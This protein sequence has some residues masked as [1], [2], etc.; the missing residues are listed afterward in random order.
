LIWSIQLQL[1][2]VAFQRGG[3][4]GVLGAD[5]G[6]VQRVLGLLVVDLGDDADVG[7]AVVALQRALGRQAVDLGG[8]GFLLGQQLL[9][10]RQDALARDVGL[11]SS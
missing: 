8:V 9:L 3:L 7:D 2:V 5:L 11:R 6:R 4:L 1:D 10:A